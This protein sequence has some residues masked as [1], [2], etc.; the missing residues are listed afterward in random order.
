MEE[1]VPLLIRADASASIGTGHIMRCLALAQAWQ[2]RGRDV[3]FICAQITSLLEER[4]KAEGFKVRTISVKPGSQED[5]KET[6]RLVED[7]VSSPL[8]LD[9]YHFDANYQ[10]G[11]KERGCR[12]LVMDD[13]GHADFYHAD[14]V[15]NQN[16]TAQEQLYARRN[17][18]TQLLLGPKYA[19]LRKEFSEYRG[20]KREIPEKARKVLVT[21]GGADPE[22]VTRG[23]IE[24]LTGLELDVKVV[25][26][27]SNPNLS[28]LREVAS[29]ASHGLTK[30]DLV[31]N[32]PNMAELLSWADLAVA[33][34][35]STSW[36]LA[37]L[38]L[39][40]IFIILA[41]NHAEIVRRLGE[42]GA[43][44]SFGYYTDTDKSRLRELVVK[45]AQD[46]V[47]RQ[48][49]SSMS[50]KLVDGRG[51]GRVIAAL[52]GNNEIEFESVA[53]KD[54]ELLWLWANDPVTRSNSFESDF[55]SW[56]EHKVWCQ[57]RM[58]DPSCDFWMVKI[59]GLGKIGC[60]RF[61]RSPSKVVMS[62]SLAPRVRG[63]GYGKRII[64]LAC[65][66][67]LRV[68]GA[69]PIHA[70]IKS[71]NKASLAAFACAG[72]NES[73]DIFVKGHAA[74]SYTFNQN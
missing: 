6:F 70:F 50:A 30:M 3:L 40:T 23:V 54:F 8:V 15:L 56:D 29:N 4:I 55:I 51:A 72:F 21:L 60:V 2:N 43:G 18:G 10:L 11:L 36:E 37:F 67:F 22:N 74:K 58:G 52:L 73:C 38:G 31:V 49:L 59:A 53:E 26:G 27:G 41:E 33:A 34:G 47:A 62:I 35:G 63:V 16:V 28:N 57:N 17:T 64:K 20:W 32:P 19:L 9:G 44:V 42:K 39:P 69:I 12:L 1:N 65:V 7:G 48:E 71:D 13:Y 46:R 14:F 68:Y 61:D 5:C 24:A 66:H 25:V 45:L